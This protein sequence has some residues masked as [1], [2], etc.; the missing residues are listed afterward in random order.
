MEIHPE[1]TSL[2]SAVLRPKGDNL[3]HTVLLVRSSRCGVETKFSL[4][5]LCS[6]TS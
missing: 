5:D 1:S 6:D 3:Q 2:M 4:P